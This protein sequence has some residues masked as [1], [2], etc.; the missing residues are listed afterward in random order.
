MITHLYLHYTKIS[1]TDLAL[2]DKATKKPYD[3]NL[4]IENLFEQINDTVDYTTAGDTPYITSQI[5][6]TAYQLVFNTGV[7]G[8]DCKEWR[9]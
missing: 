6:S 7:F 8:L 1:P 4:P 9:K 5:L 2:N 3:P